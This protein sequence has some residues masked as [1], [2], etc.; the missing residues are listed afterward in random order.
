M[1]DDY[2][3]VDESESNITEHP[4]LAFFNKSSAKATSIHDI[5][6]TLGSAPIMALLR[7]L[8]KWTP[9]KFGVLIWGA[10]HERD[11][12]KKSLYGEC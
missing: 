10:I 12:S 9:Q 4:V 8:Q 3:G 2:Q 11:I 7:V 1:R 6:M 5:R